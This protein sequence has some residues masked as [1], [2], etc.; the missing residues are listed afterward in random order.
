MNWIQEMKKY[1]AI[2]VATLLALNALIIGL[3]VF[4]GPTIVSG[5]S[6]SGT[7]GDPYQIDDVDDLQAVSTNS[8]LYYII[9]D[10]IEAGATENWNWDSGE[11]RFLGFDPIGHTND[12]FQGNID[13]NGKTITGLY[14]D[15]PD[16]NHV[17]LIADN[18]G[19][20]FD[21]TLV[22][23]QITGDAYVGG[24]AGES[25]GAIEDCKSHGT[26][27]GSDSL[28][29]GLVGENLGSGTVEGCSTDGSVTGGELER[30]VGGLV[31]VNWNTIE[32]CSSTA[33]PT[34]HNY[35]GGLV[36]H[37][38]GGITLSFAVSSVIG[39]DWVGGLVG[40]S[41]NSSVIQDCYAKG[42]VD[43]DAD[44][45]G[46]LVGHNV[47]GSAIDNAYYVG[48]VDGGGNYEGGLVGADDSPT[49]ALIT[50][51]FWSEDNCAVSDGGEDKVEDD[52]ENYGMNDI[53]TYIYEY[54]SDGLDDAWDFQGTD[55]NDN[56]NND[57]WDIDSGKNGGF[58]YF[59][60]SPPVV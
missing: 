28:I 32:D 17:G 8:G 9:T 12:E 51:S 38:N 1:N 40:Q 50:N 2:M 31:G 5:M 11:G 14:I 33:N 13:G 19:S 4:P 29:G 36:G 21:I 34:G 41:S 10:D 54:Y 46:G 37:N 57:Y 49:N 24:L 27:E 23:S 7:S 3:S 60:N 26:I 45:V 15:R 20:L 44:Y 59:Y 25:N 42:G 30:F 56:E 43:G 48:S 53:D 35:I 6:G 18:D 39:N 55:R 52:D 22:N 47:D 58:P 16:T